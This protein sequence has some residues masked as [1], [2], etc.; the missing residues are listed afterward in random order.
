MHSSQD[1]HAD[2][3]QRHHFEYYRIER[4]LEINRYYSNF[5]SKNDRLLLLQ[6]ISTY[7]IGFQISA[8]VDSDYQFTKVLVLRVPSRVPSFDLIQS[9]L[10]QQQSRI[11][12]QVNSFWL[13][14]HVIIYWMTFVLWLHM[15]R[16]T[17]FELYK[18]WYLEVL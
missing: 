18:C 5:Q 1:H 16:N 7:N 3:H 13:P 12:L 9:K 11:F 4:K 10:S 8:G 15:L 6:C 17:P 2:L 14:R